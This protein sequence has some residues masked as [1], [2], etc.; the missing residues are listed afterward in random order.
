M[1][2]QNPTCVAFGGKDY[3]DLYVTTSQFG[4]TQDELKDK[5]DS[6]GIFKITGLGV[7]GYPPYRAQL[8]PDILNKVK[9]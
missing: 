3:S 2:V 5:P 4:F 1:P 8:H 9:N 7:K 6:G